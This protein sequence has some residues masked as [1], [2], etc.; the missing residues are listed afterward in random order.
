MTK[1]LKKRKE[2]QAQWL[3]PVILT[4]QRRSEGF[5]FMPAQANSSQDPISING[6]A[7]WFVPVIPAA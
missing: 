2:G 5:Q 1:Q 6:W 4:T 7:R 3:K